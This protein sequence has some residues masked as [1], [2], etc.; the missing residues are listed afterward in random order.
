MGNSNGKITAPVSLH[1]DVYPVLGLTKTGT[2][3]DIGHACGNTHG[4]TNPW[5]KYKPVRFSSP[6]GYAAN[7]NWWKGDDGLCGLAIPSASGAPDSILNSE[8]GYNAPR[9]GQDWCR[10]AD[11][12]G[13][14]HRCTYFLSGWMRTDEIRID[15]GNP[16]LYIQCS[17]KQP[18]AQNNLQV[19][20][21]ELVSNFR[22]AVRIKAGSRQ[23]IITS[24]K[25]AS[26]VLDDSGI[27]QVKIDFTDFDK[28][29]LESSRFTL[30]QFFTT[31]S[32]PELTT[33]PTVITCYSVPNYMG[34]AFGNTKVV[35]YSN[36]EFGLEILAEGLASSLYGTYQTEDY[37][38]TSP[39]QVKAASHEYWKLKVT[40]RATTAKTLS[41]NQLEW[42]GI[43]A[44][45]DDVT[46]NYNSGE[47]RL[48]N[49]S[50]VQ[51]Y[52][53]T[54][55]P[56]TETTIYAQTRLFS[57]GAGI[58]AGMSPVL[59]TCFAYY[60]APADNIENQL[61]ARFEVNIQGSV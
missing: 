8:W 25:K 58:Y 56:D 20:D 41:V 46:D 33:F 57:K 38:M 54:F 45:G 50:R 24:D 44:V 59:G 61:S 28:F 12:D 42:H 27:L 17:L 11:W 32:Y 14:N 19:T 35:N 21:V 31:S 5:A 4:Q 3:Y 23:W 22:L 34:S 47:L 1:A 37:Y 48:Y 15:R 30:D 29:G 51:E 43:N 9:P 55:Q 52:S 53:M 10:L 60:S 2:F 6:A 7:A 13:Y 40:N 18:T 16:V 36:I 49:S 39:F 26:E